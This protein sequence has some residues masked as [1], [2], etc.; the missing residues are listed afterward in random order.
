LDAAAFARELG[1]RLGRTRQAEVEF[2]IA[3]AEFDRRELFLELGSSSLWDYCMR[4]LHLRE[5]ATYRRTHAA[6][7]LRRF[8]QL[9]EL[10]RDGRLCLSTLCELE[11]ILTE[12]NF[13]SLV[14]Q[15]AFRT[16]REVQQLACGLRPAPEPPGDALR[17]APVR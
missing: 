17:R 7:L 2:L 1:R 11:P 8:P 16:K 10:L 3:L 12:A 9:A 14:A 15:A 4:A 5:G 13:E 6:R